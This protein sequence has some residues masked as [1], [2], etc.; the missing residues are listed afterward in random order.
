MICLRLGSGIIVETGRTR[1]NEGCETEENAMAMR[2]Q[3]VSFVGND[4][5]DESMNCADEI[6]LIRVS[7]FQKMIY[8]II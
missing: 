2:S 1:G 3:A 7:I 4:L 6:K 5:A 8:Y